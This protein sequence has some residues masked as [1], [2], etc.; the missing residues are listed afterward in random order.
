MNVGIL[1]QPL[2]HN[3]G[4]VLQ[5]WALQKI[6]EELG[7]RPY[8]IRYYGLTS[9]RQLA[10][11]LRSIIS[12]LIKSL[13]LNPDRN[14][15]SVPWDRKNPLEELFKFLKNHTKRTVVLTGLSGETLKKYQ[16]GAI[17]IGS[18]QV[19]RPK[20]NIEHLNLMFGDFNFDVPL[21]AYAASFGVNSWEFNE[22]QTVMARERL[23][24]FKFVSVREV[25]AVGLCESYLGV[26]AAFVLDPTLLLSHEQYATLV[27]K[28]SDG[29]LYKD[30]ICVYILD[31]SET[32]RI[33]VDS[34]CKTLNLAPV[35]VGTPNPKTGKYC[36]I[37]TWLSAID[38]SAFTITDSFHGTAFAINFNKPFIS[39]TNKKRG[40]ARLESI[41]QIFGLE[42]RL[43]DERHVNLSSIVS[44]TINWSKV[45]ELLEKYREQSLSALSDALA[46]KP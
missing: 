41:L 46:Y 6:L 26:R 28:P 17:I 37:E 35:Y 42:K 45:N 2:G 18:D 8:T 15:V 23:K 32:K 27:T 5:N 24:K 13:L 12:F 40:N 43:I 1:T 11:D 16:L 7:H 21:I 25:S 4:G 14:F 34:I 38:N 9:R 33:I 31:L 10:C 29:Q 36:K 3:Y 30:K 39:I 44:E 20:Y 22:D 19:W